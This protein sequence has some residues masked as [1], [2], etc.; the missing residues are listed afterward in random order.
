M[1]ASFL[2]IFYTAYSCAFCSACAEKENYL[3]DYNAFV[4]LDDTDNWL[5][6]FEVRERKYARVLY[7]G[8]EHVTNLTSSLLSRSRQCHPLNAWR[9]LMAYKVTIKLNKKWKLWS[10][11]TQVKYV[12]KTTMLKKKNN[13]QKILFT[14]QV[15]DFRPCW[16][17][18][19]FGKYILFNLQRGC[20]TQ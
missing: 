3:K 4:K 6:F 8:E 7:H 11:L 16:S 13:V 1:I 2:T 5:L 17:C 12:W 9:I 18:S 15:S 10:A 20:Y 19:M 14:L